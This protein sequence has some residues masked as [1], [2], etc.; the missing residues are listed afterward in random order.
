MNH[1]RLTATIRIDGDDSTAPRN[2]THDGRE[3]YLNARGDASIA[4][5][6]EHRPVT[7]AWPRHPKV[8]SRSPLV[9]NGTC[10]GDRWIGGIKS[11]DECTRSGRRFAGPLIPL[12]APQESIDALV[13]D[14]RVGRF[15]DPGNRR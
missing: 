6:I 7:A 4:E 15:N 2:S 1:P 8:N 5:M 9:C 12:Q 14:E 10:T 3:A 11:L 13:L